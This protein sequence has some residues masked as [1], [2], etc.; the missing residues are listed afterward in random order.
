MQSLAF[1]WF[2]SQMTQRYLN[3][4]TFG[5]A[6]PRANSA[7]LN[8]PIG[9]G[10]LKLASVKQV[11]R[12]AS[13]NQR[14]VSWPKARNFF[15]GFVFGSPGSPTAGAISGSVAATSKNFCPIRRG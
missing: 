15:G 5:P 9:A 11:P 1:L 12:T 2:D 10:G 6:Q 7:N 3:E 8:T 14:R 4:I 13:A